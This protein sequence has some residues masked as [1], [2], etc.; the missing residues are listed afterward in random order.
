[1]EDCRRW[2]WTDVG[3]PR[4]AVAATVVQAE[5]MING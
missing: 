5:R 4:Q 2:I 1:M 3:L